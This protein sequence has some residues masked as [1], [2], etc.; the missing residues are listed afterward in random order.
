[1]NNRTV[2]DHS[3]ETKFH[4]FSRTIIIIIY[5]LILQEL[6]VCQSAPHLV[7]SSNQKG[8]C[9]GMRRLAL[10]ISVTQMFLFVCVPGCVNGLCYFTGSSSTSNRLG[11][12][13]Y[14]H[15]CKHEHVCTYI[16]THTHKLLTTICSSG[17]K[18]CVCVCVVDLGYQSY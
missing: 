9:T 15:V 4:P 14:T 17:A 16:H 12:S 10:T 7:H 3:S 6:A 5:F 11:S 13:L 1:M 18:S 8:N 2:G